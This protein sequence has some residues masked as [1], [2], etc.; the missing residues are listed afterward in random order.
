MSHIQDYFKELEKKGIVLNEGQKL[1]YE[2]KMEMLGEGMRKEYPSTPDEAFEVN[3]KG[4]Y[5]A[6]QVSIARAQKRILNIPYDQSCRVHTAWDLGF[7]DATS[8]IFFQLQG[9]EIHIIDFVEGV[10]SSMAV[11]IKTVKDKPY[12]YGTHLAP[13]D[14]KI[15]EYSTGTTR[16]DTAFKLGIS[17]SLVPDMGLID[18]ID[19]VRN[20]FP[21]LY[22]HNS[23]DVLSLVKRIENYSQGW[24]RTAGL[25]SGKPTH[26]INSHAA[27]ALRY[28]CVGLDRCLDES[29]SMSAEQAENAFKT[30]GRRI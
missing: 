11:Y 2:K 19:V 5:F 13:H 6:V 23:D 8:I 21:R 9:R 7:R 26:D 17:F 10:G 14:I 20:N 12:I 22:F 15:H 3:T 18:G 28:L 25:W 30:Y 29:Q 16:F 1:W 4:L 27:D 24:D